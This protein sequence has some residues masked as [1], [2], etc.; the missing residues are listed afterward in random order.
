M[1]EVM[2]QIDGITLEEQMNFLETAK[3]I[4]KRNAQEL[5]KQIME[6]DPFVEVANAETEKIK[7]QNQTK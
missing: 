5:I 2:K 6:I 1:E 7:A 4:G 3:K